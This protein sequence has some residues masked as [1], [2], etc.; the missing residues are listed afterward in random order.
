MRAS[1]TLQPSTR[2]PEDRWCLLFV[3]ETCC[4]HNLNPHHLVHLCSQEALPIFPLVPSSLFY[5]G[6]WGEGTIDRITQLADFGQVV[7]IH[8]HGLFPTEGDTTI[9]DR[10]KL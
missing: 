10:Q 8:A 4:M 3:F 9:G 5:Y 1:T 7:R 2:D 6:A